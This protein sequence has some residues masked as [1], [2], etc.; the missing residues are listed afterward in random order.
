MPKILVLAVLIAI[1][2][3][4][5]SHAEQSSSPSSAL[6]EQNETGVDA[7]RG[8][9]SA[10]GSGADPSKLPPEFQEQF[11]DV[12]AASSIP[13]AETSASCAE[14]KEGMNRDWDKIMQTIRELA[15]AK[16]KGE[17][18]VLDTMKGIWALK[19]VAWVAF[20]NA[21]GSEQC[22][23]EFEKENEKRF[24]AMTKEI[25]TLTE[26]IKEK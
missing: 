15:E 23:K 18:G 4:R 11:K 21:T 6:P 2:V 13:A 8:N 3:C 17:L 24:E 22:V 14:F 10:P 20:R 1:A 26:E 19:A 5:P 9:S 12:A 16:K 25:E 7:H